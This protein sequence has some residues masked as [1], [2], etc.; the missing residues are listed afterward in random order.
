MG[1]LPGSDCSLGSG[2][3]LGGGDFPGGGGLPGAGGLPSRVGGIYGSGGLPRENGLS[4]DSL[5]GGFNEFARRG[6]DDSLSYMHDGWAKGY[7]VV[8]D[9]RGAG[10]GHHSDVGFQTAGGE[11]IYDDRGNAQ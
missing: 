2:G 11:H 4:G 10:I 9:V 5:H 3:L 6:F 8:P 1:G 7:G